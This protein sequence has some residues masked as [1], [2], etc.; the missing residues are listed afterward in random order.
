MSVTASQIADQMSVWPSSLSACRL[1]LV[2][3]LLVQAASIADAIPGSPGIQILPGE[4]MEEDVYDLGQDSD[5]LNPGK[6]DREQAEDQEGF[7]DG[8]QPYFPG[9]SNDAWPDPMH[10]GG[11][12]KNYCWAA[13]SGFMGSL[14]NTGVTSEWCYTT[15]AHSQSRKYVWCTHWNQCQGTWKCGG[16]CAAI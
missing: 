13:C 14:S 1:A 11:C 9:F 7:R 16:P 2:I 8:S 6:L 5:W 3:L 10:P 12:Y 4:V 15:K